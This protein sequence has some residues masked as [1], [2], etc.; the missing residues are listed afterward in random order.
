MG[1]NIIKYYG[2]DNTN[3]ILKIYN[4]MYFNVFCWF[5]SINLFNIAG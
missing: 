3:Y 1:A 4:K 2:I 5:L